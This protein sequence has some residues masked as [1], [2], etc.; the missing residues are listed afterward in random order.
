MVSSEEWSGYGHYLAD[1]HT[2][3]RELTELLEFWEAEK[4]RAEKYL[5][6]I[7]K[8]LAEIE[9]SYPKERGEK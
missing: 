8:R 4:A 6:E 1:L 3:H 5:A 9:E 7:K 2:E